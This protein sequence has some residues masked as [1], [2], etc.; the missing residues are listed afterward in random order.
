[1]TGCAGAGE[2]PHALLPQE[3]LSLPT[4]SPGRHLPAGAE[5]DPMAA[6]LRVRCQGRLHNLLIPVQGR[7][8]PRASPGTP[9]GVQSKVH[10]L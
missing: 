5:P 4:C 6:W 10:G 3:L 1:M 7:A 8:V 9:Q 2:V